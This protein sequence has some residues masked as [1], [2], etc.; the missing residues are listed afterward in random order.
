[1]RQEVWLHRVNMTISI[2][3]SICSF[4]LCSSSIKALTAVHRSCNTS[5]STAAPPPVKQQAITFHYQ[6]FIIPTLLTPLVQLLN[7]QLKLLYVNLG[8]DTYTICLWC[9][10]DTEKNDT[11]DAGIQE[12]GNRGHR[13]LR[14]N[15]TYGNIRLETWPWNTEHCVW[16]AEIC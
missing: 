16:Y 7:I 2:F 3:F 8:A 1:M 4:F 10:Q 6:Y 15:R 13:N 12:H 5:S 9:L 11:A 14:K